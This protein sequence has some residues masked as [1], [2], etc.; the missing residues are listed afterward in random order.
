MTVS[1]VYGVV[2]V[3][4]IVGFVFFGKIWFLLGNSNFG[5]ITELDLKKLEF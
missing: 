5:K 2:Y 3:W 1:Y 4:L